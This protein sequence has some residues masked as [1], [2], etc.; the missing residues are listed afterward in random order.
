M[1]LLRTCS[2]TSSIFP[3]HCYFSVPSTNW[4]RYSKE[5]P[6][7]LDVNATI[8]SDTTTPDHHGPHAEACAFW[9]K[10]LPAI[11][12]ASECL[13]N[14]G[15][16]S[17]GMSPPQTCGNFNPQSGPSNIPSRPQSQQPLYYVP[18]FSSPPQ[19]IPH[20]QP[21]THS[22]PQYQQ[23]SHQPLQT[24]EPPVLTSTSTS[25]KCTVEEGPTSSTPLQGSS[26]G[27]GSPP[28]ARY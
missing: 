27:F 10:L 15:H 6:V 26:P 7:Y 1:N 16:A 21:V 28:P 18:V 3:F 17:G 12:A 24:T 22:N 13:V 23:C 14:P 25:C 5:N 8:V 9:N 19:D 11:G 4:E 2:Y 20:Q